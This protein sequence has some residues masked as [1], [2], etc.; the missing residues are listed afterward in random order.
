VRVGDRS[1]RL[2]GGRDLLA[3]ACDLG[4]SAR[5]VSGVLF[6]ARFELRR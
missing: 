3:Q 5:Q 6:I 1:V 4:I 2:F